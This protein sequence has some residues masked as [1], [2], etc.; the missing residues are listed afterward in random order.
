MLLPV[1]LLVH[2]EAAVV[3]AGARAGVPIT[4]GKNHT[5][6]LHAHRSLHG[7]VHLDRRYVYIMNESSLH[8]DLLHVGLAFHAAAF[9]EELAAAVGAVEARWLRVLVLRARA[10]FCFLHEEAELF[11]EV[12]QLEF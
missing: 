12:F 10:A 11:V 4:F 9:R 6:L 3:L 2:D 1:L 5:R 7:R 8:V